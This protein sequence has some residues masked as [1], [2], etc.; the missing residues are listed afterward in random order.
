MTKIVNRNKSKIQN[1]IDVEW[2]AIARSPRKCNISASIIIDRA[3]DIKALVKKMGRTLKDYDGAV[4]VYS[5]QSR[6]SRGI[7][8]LNFKLAID[9][10]GFY[11]IGFQPGVS[12]DKANELKLILPNLNANEEKIYGINWGNC[13]HLIDDTLRCNFYDTEIEFDYRLNNLRD[14]KELIDIFN[15]NLKPC[16]VTLIQ[17]RI[18][19]SFKASHKPKSYFKV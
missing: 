9:K 15:E 4:V 16:S 19:N 10:N 13:F 7:V 3:N 17:D 11:L 18:K 5:E 14:S 2:G 1:K 8:C 6:N 12:S